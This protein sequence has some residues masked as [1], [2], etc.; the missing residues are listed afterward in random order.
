VNDDNLDAIHTFSAP[1]RDGIVDALELDG[2]T[3]LWITYHLLA[4]ANNGNASVP[5]RWARRLTFGDLPPLAV[6]SALEIKEFT[7]FNKTVC[8]V[9]ESSSC[10][11]LPALLDLKVFR[12]RRLDPNWNN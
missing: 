1:A 6:P 12:K 5:C 3:S 9:R 2:F 11:F 4:L 8:P 10:P 7:A